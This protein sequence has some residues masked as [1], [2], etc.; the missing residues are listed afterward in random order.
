MKQAPV[1]MFALAAPFAPLPLKEAQ[2]TLCIDLV[3]F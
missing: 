1:Y 3:L 2:I